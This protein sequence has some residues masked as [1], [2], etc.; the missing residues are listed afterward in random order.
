MHNRT[1][2]ALL[3]WYK[4]EVE[5]FGWMV[6]F[7]QEFQNTEIYNDF[8]QYRLNVYLESLDKLLHALDY[9]WLST[10][11]NDIKNDIYIM[12]TSLSHFIPIVNKILN[13]NT[14]LPPRWEI[15]DE[16]TA[17]TATVNYY[18]ITFHGAAKWFK[19]AVE[20]LGWMVMLCHEYHSDESFN[21][22]KNLKI[23]TYIKSLE[24]LTLSIHNKILLEQNNIT[25]LYDLNIIRN[26]LNLKFIN[27]V[28]AII[29]LCYNIEQ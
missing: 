1:Y 24:I 22:F 14:N 6:I 2:P 23:V 8:C 7:K 21:K 26:K 28:K 12:K 3:K 29:K 27:N 25:H 5:K 19:C 13:N 15:V 17:I 4:K 16:M 9:K 18:R 10:T 11:C 20:K